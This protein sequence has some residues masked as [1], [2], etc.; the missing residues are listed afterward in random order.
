[1]ASRRPPHV[2]SRLPLRLRLEFEHLRDSA[3]ALVK[4][5]RARRAIPLLAKAPVRRQTLSGAEANDV[6]LA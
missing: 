1:L 5:S 3:R 6:L 4:N 2:P